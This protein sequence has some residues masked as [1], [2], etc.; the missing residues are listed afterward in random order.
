MSCLPGFLTIR[1][2]RVPHWKVPAGGPPSGLTLLDAL[3]RFRVIA[4]LLSL[5]FLSFMRG[6]GQSLPT[7]AIA[8]LQDEAFLPFAHRKTA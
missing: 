5:P 3:D 4:G 7:R 2:A 6:I 8:A 1:Q